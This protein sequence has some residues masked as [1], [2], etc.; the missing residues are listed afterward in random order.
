M[1]TT[2]VIFFNLLQKQER[3]VEHVENKFN[4]WCNKFNITVKSFKYATWFV[5]V[6]MRQYS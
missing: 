3:F 5:T 2:G 4:K 1:F 6:L